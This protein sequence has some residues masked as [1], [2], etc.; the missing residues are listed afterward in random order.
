MIKIR[1]NRYNNRVYVKLFTVFSF[2]QLFM[3]WRLL[4]LKVRKLRIFKFF[5]DVYISQLK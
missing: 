2:I 4:Q 3:F 5:E 1:V